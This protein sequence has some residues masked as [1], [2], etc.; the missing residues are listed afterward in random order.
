MIDSQ[1]VNISGRIVVNRPKTK[2]NTGNI[3]SYRAKA[4]S[5]RRNHHFKSE[6]TCV[7]YELVISP[8]TIQK[9]KKSSSLNTRRIQLCWFIPRKVIRRRQRRAKTSGLLVIDSNNGR[10]D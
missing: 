2:K 9:L 4:T 5:P 1:V 7:P 3:D 8:E 10:K 6:P